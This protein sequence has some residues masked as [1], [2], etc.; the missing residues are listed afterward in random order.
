MSNHGTTRRQ[1]LAGA[2][3]L[4]AAAMLTGLGAASRAGAAAP[5][6]GGGGFAPYHRFK[7]GGFEV[8]TLLAGT[9]T[10]DNPHQIF[11]LNVDGETFAQASREA[12]LPVDRAQFFFTPTLVN[13]GAE[14]I[15]FD[16]GLNAEGITAALAA[17]GHGPEQVDVV[18]LTHMHGDHIG[19]LMR[20]GEPTFA[21]ARYVTGAHEHNHWSGTDNEGF[22]NSVVPLNA[23][24]S[25]LDPGG[26]AASGVTALPAFGHTPG[27]MAYMIESEGRGLVLIADAANHAVWSLERP[28]WEV[29]F[30]TCFEAVIDACA[31]IPRGG[32]AGTWITAEMRQAYLALHRLGHAHSVEV[33]AGEELVGGLYGVGIGRMF[34]GESMFSAASGGSKIALAA[35][36]RRLAQAG[37]PLLDAQVANPHLQR[38]G[39]TPMPRARFLE[40]V[41]GLCAAPCP[42]DDWADPAARTTTATLAA[43]SSTAS[44]T[45]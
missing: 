9:R 25:F 29:R 17:A 8:T 3:L 15:L 10:V 20:D 27:H 37:C 44:P 23:R 42:I 1:A 34:F 31:T 39:G 35:L 7:L 19:G 33:F 21:N 28:D 24:M 36:A 38:L 45:P 5:M 41:S 13:T 4:P 11:G 40:Q 16:T 22:R 6:A 32:E 2:A 30:D 43:G 26:A 12:F 14:L 18:V